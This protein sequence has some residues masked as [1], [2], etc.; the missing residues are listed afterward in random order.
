MARQKFTDVDLIAALNMHQGHVAKA[1]KELGVSRAA[2]AKR[3]DK[4]PQGVL[5]PSME[6]FRA[7]RADIFTDMQKIIMQY[8]TPE[9]LKKA[10]LQQLGTLFGI[11]Y[12]KERLEKNLATEHIAHVHHKSLST[13]DK[14]A[15]QDM[16]KWMTDR[17]RQEI[18][19]DD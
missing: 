16:I 9:K 19:Y 2:I 8:I 14:T 18:T 3:M 11:F 13:E 7:K 5:S 1:A 6:D 15:L 12:D 4:L 17:K 10:S